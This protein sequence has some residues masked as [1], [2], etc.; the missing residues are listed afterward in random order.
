MNKNEKRTTYVEE[1]KQK[2]NTKP[3]AN[4]PRPPV[5]PAPQKPPQKR[6]NGQKEQ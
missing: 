2:G 3:P 5:E 4:G 1:G 6:D